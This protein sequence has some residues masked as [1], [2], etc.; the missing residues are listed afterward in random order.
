L[1]DLGVTGIEAAENLDDVRA[2]FAELDKA[3]LEK[4]N[5]KLD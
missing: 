5:A 1:A 2:I 4:A 3:D